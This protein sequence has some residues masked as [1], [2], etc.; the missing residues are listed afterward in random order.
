M[1]FSQWIVNGLVVLTKVIDMFWVCTSI[2]LVFL[3]WSLVFHP[4]FSNDIHFLV[5]LTKHCHISCVKFQTFFFLDDAL[6]SFTQFSQR[7]VNVL[8]VLTKFNNMFLV[9]LSIFLVFLSSALLFHTH[10][11]RKI[12]T[13]AGMSQYISK[14]SACN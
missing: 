3:W 6:V 9:S 12:A 14:L 2:F 5:V 7:I 1:K 4:D 13:L 10:I 8:I 11:S